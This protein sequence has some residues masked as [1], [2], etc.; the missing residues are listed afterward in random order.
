MVRIMSDMNKDQLLK[1]LESGT[2]FD[3]RAL[4]E[5]REVSIEYHISGTAEGSARVTFGD[6]VVIAGVK[7]DMGSPFPDRPD[8]GAITVNAELLPL[9]NPNFESGPP[10]I[11]SIELARVVD[12]GIRESKAIDLK[13]LV[14]K[15]GEKCWVVSID[16]C[17]VNACGNLFDAAA[18]AAL[19]ALQDAKYP[20]YDGE[21]VDY[22]THTSKSLVLEKLPITVTVVKIG[23]YLLVDPLYE[24]EQCLD[25][26]L[27]VTTTP[28]GTICALQKGGE[29]PLSLDEIKQMIEMASRKA[30]E[31]R[32]KLK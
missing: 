15:K 22:K 13:K 18:L 11:E 5:F 21:K 1:F 25:A 23:N 14:L 29:S 20:E 26:R 12:R 10:G 31:I 4:D 3:G 32:A 6:T 8:E 9:S 7:L 2:R 19:A 28:D 16:V 24:E 27:T 30:K 17:T